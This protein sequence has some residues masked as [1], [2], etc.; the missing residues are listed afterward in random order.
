MDPVDAPAAAE[1][2][3]AEAAPVET[4]VGYAYSLVF[5]CSLKDA[6]SSSQ[7]P[8]YIW[9]QADLHCAAVKVRLV[10]TSLLQVNEPDHDATADTT[11]PTDQE[12]AAPVSAD[13]ATDVTEAAAS[14]AKPQR[15][16]YG[17]EEWETMAIPDQWHPLPLLRVRLGVGLQ[18]LCVMRIVPVACIGLQLGSCTCVHG[19][20]RW[21]HVCHDLHISTF[22]LPPLI[23]GRRPPS[24]P[25][26]VHCVPPGAWHPH[27]R[28]G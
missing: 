24:L 5:V 13:P 9:P 3:P 22:T 28:D 27:H 16:D 19:R 2:T 11:A 18:N 25:L 8:C 21:A 1:Q 7:A 4:K 26:L 17:P 20:R 23:P 10:V 12:Q 15:P 14:P 6:A